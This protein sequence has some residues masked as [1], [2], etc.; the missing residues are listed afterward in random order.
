[1]TCQ[2]S[3]T[4]NT[5]SVLFRNLLSSSS[6]SPRSDHYWQHYYMKTNNISKFSYYSCQI[7]LSSTIVYSW[8]IGVKGMFIP[9]ISRSVEAVLCF[10]SPLYQIISSHQFHQLSYYLSPISN[11]NYVSIMCIHDPKSTR[12]R[13]KYILSSTSSELTYNFS[14]TNYRILYYHEMEK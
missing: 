6:V 1:M 11:E 5:L 4:G 14:T 13:K 9:L 2:T 7:C 12:L 10:T 8:D 3:H